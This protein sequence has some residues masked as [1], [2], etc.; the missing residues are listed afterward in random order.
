MNIIGKT[1]GSCVINECLILFTTDNS[2]DRIY[3]IKPPN[4]G[5]VSDVIKLFDGD[6]KFSLS[7]KIQTLA[8]YENESIQKVYWIDGIN[9]PRVINVS[10][11]D[12][13][14]HLYQ[15]TSFDFIQNLELNELVGVEKLYTG[16]YFKSGVI[17]Y[18]ITYFNK[19]G[20]ES[21]IFWISDINYIS[22]DDRGGKVDEVIQ[23]SFKISIENLENKYE[24]IR[25]YSIYRT[26]IDSTVEVRSIADLEIPES[27]SIIFIDS[28]TRG[29]IVSSDLLLYVGGEELIPKCMSQKNNTLFLGNINLP[30]N[31][32][33]PPTL[34]TNFE[35]DVISYGV[36]AHLST[37]EWVKKTTIIED[38]NTG[39]SMYPYRPFV[40]NVRHFKFDETYRFGVQGQFQNGKW[41]SPMWI[42]D[43]Y[44][45]ND[46]Y[47]TKYTDNNSKIELEY[48]N[49]RYNVASELKNW[50]IS[51]GFKKVRPVMVPL[52]YS[53]RTIIAQGIVNNTL[54][55][56]K[57][58][59][60]GRGSLPFSYPDYTFR[61]GGVQKTPMSHNG[62]YSHFDLLEVNTKLGVSTPSEYIEILG[63][64]GNLSYNDLSQFNSNSDDDLFFVDR[65]IVNFWSPD[66]SNNSDTLNSYVKNVTSAGLYGFSFQSGLVSNFDIDYGNIIDD[67]YSAT[68]TYYPKTINNYY[69][70]VDIFDKFKSRRL[71]P[72][73]NATTP[74]NPD[75][76]HKTY[77]TIPIWSPENY[78]IQ[79]PQRASNYG[80]ESIDINFTKF[81]KSAFNYYGVNRTIK[82]SYSNYKYDINNPYLVINDSNIYYKS[83]TSDNTDNN[84][85][86]LYS[87]NVNKIYPSNTYFNTIKYDVG[88]DGARVGLLYSKY[89]DTIDNGT[90][91]ESFPVKSGMYIRYNTNVHGLF[92]FKDNQ[93]KS[94]C[95]PRLQNVGESS[96]YE[97]I[98]SPSF[99]RS[100]G[101]EFKVDIVGRDKLNDPMS[102][103]D[104]TTVNSLPIFDLYKSVDDS[105]R[106]GGK[107]SDALYNNTWIPC[108]PSIAVSNNQMI[109]EYIVGDTY[110]GRFDLLRV[111]PND[112]N[113]IVQ[114]TEIISFL[115]ESFINMDGRSDVNRY[116]VD[117]SLMTTS[118]YGLFNNIYSQKN[119]Y[120]NYSILDPVLFN[121]SNYSNTIVWT[122]TKI[123]GSINDS[124]T[125]LNM[126][127][128][129]DLDGTYGE[130]SSLNIFNSDLYAFQPK[131]V[132]RLLFNER[133]QQ[134]ASD[135]VSVE[136][137]NGYKVP[138]YRYLSNQYGASNKW[139]IIEGKQ[140][141]YFI[142]YAN[143]S[144][145]S[146]GDGIKDLGLSLGFKSWFNENVVGRDFNLSYDRVNND[147][148]I[149]DDTD[150]LNYSETLGSF[151]S[152]FDYINVPQMK[153][154]WDS[155]ISIGYSEAEDE[156][157]ANKSTVWL[158]NKGDYNMFY[159]I[160]KPFSVE[161]LVNPE[162]LSDKVFNTFEYRLNDQFIDWN[163]L[164]LKNW[165]Q[166]GELNDR[167]YLNSL[168]RKFNVNRVQ[169]PRQ[170]KTLD[171]STG[172]VML[173]TRNSLNRIRSTWSKLKLSHKTTA[174]NI[175]KKFDM[176][177]LT[178]TYTI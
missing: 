84:G 138:E 9:Q 146:I 86:V 63:N 147:L 11:D 69:S 27:R 169:L 120:F 24:N 67:D 154:V 30:N 119:N 73:M 32:I 166:Y 176:Q 59:H 143:R 42:G 139:S 102:S 142:D 72:L 66:L 23:N 121:T 97:Y 17:Q 37:F 108:G 100:T 45:V 14:I 157:D 144:L 148:Y 60:S 7:N 53:D 49:A 168:K 94:I 77:H 164:E 117:S 163:S 149:H 123:S 151:V 156:S 15:N 158:H 92:S 177:D 118:N 91:I 130:V 38:L 43:D 152:F 96:L 18:A 62:M 31:R 65:N 58:R 41:S 46:R 51:I 57:N 87:K 133:V 26:S 159:G 64:N 5:G 175:N 170:S 150:C 13:R 103:S 28:G 48:I 136:L 93:S 55:V 16:G 165:Y 110:I 2:S 178:V 155:F 101:N 89:I 106:Y 20:A 75:K 80:S 82:S 173:D 115:C 99:Y 34:S 68:S 112:I 137:T 174:V 140:G 74:I 33:L 95:M 22:T 145:M 90:T 128:S 132:A 105:V 111:F 153:N 8:F 88:A 104:Y 54:G 47:S 40:S 56:I 171:N 113:Q 124:W 167:Q 10:I 83:N 160:P 131:G 116:N 76:P 1:I 98:P 70:G 19:N 44:K 52:S 12:S 122:S 172:L 78:N 126:L 79:L 161:Y 109:I 4:S 114:H 39:G 141:V 3:K 81:N 25:I 107:T 6:L 29:S 50:F 134:Q 127:N 35:H 135:G 71:F 21:N 125:N 129:I 61:N 162:P 36:P 85:N